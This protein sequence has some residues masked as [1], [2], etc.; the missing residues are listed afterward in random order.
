MPATARVAIVDLNN[1]ATFP[2]LAVGLLVAA[3]RRAGHTVEVLCPLAH[4]VPAAVRERREGWLDHAARRIHLSTHPLFTLGRDVAR[5]ARWWWRTRPHAGVLRETQRVLDTRPDV[6]LLS[7][8]LQHYRTVEAIGRLAAARGV[9]LLLGGPAFSHAA[10]ADTWRRLPG[11][12][13]LVAGE[14][15]RSL[16]DLLATL[17]AGGDLLAHEGVVL[18][19]GRSSAPARPLHD[20]DAIPTPDFTDFPW[21]RYRIRVVPTMAG[22]GCQWNRCRFCSDI[23]S[24]SGRTFRT[25]SLDVVLRELE[26][27]A[28]RHATTNFLFLDLKLNSQP[29]LFR[30]LAEHLPRRVPGAQWIGTVHV[31]RRADNGLSRDDLQAA[32]A[33]GMRRISFGLESGSQRILDLVDKGSTVAGNAEFVRNAAAAGLS[34]RCTM[35]KGYPGETAGDVEA[36]AAFLEANEESIDRVRCNEFSV[37]EGTPIYDELTGPA[38]PHA[39]FEIVRLDA[40]NAAARYRNH[41]TADAAYRRAKRRMLAAVHR[42]NRRPV[43]QQAA[44]FDGLM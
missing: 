24:V 41:A 39:G 30:G 32:A 28:Q 29:A 34:V 16:P 17:R 43:R 13:A 27:Q 11:L 31:D 6:L 1:F 42:I 38:S 25:R 7:A 37:L 35:F 8:Y 20:L 26:E 9:P 36:T 4:D 5:Q 40:R 2:T 3:L 10:T 19:D 12:T 14:V 18:P 33:A 44:A 21:D 15:D 22:R 23:V